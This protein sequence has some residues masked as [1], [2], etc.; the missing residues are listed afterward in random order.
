[1]GKYAYDLVVR[2]G[3]LADARAARFTRP[4]SR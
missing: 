4:T 3:T 2:G 1:M